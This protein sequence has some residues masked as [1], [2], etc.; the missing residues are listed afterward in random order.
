[1][2]QPWKHRKDSKAVNFQIV[3]QSVKHIYHETVQH[4]L[5]SAFTMTAIHAR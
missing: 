5:K 3:K 2:L 4:L 1:M